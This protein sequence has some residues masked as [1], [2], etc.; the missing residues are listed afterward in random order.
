MR[1]VDNYEF[2]QKEI[3]IQD[4]NSILGKHFNKFLSFFLRKYRL[5]KANNWKNTFW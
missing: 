3:L 1:D 4:Q 5:F 2:Q